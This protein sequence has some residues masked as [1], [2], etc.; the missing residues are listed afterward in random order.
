MM[1]KVYTPGVDSGD[2]MAVGVLVEVLVVVVF[3][4]WFDDGLMMDGSMMDGS[5]AG[6]FVGLFH[7]GSMM[8]G[9]MMDGSKDGLKDD[10]MRVQWGFDDG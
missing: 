2:K 10:L 3:G 5:K 9:S 1:I 7:D 4:W 6:W 8:D